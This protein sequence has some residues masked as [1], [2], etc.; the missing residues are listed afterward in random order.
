[1]SMIRPRWAMP[2]SWTFGLLGYSVLIV[3]SPESLLH[4]V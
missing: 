4:F 2:P 1:L 3:W